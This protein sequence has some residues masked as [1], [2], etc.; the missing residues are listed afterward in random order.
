[1]LAMVKQLL[2]HVQDSS[3]KKLPIDIGKVSFTTTLNLLSNT[4]FSM[5][6]ANYESNTSQELKNLVGNIMKEMGSLNHCDFT[7]WYGKPL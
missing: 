4:I 5:E 6:L 7:K 3:I 1:M 2:A